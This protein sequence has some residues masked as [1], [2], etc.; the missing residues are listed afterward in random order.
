MQ[1]QACLNIAEAQPNLSKCLYSILL[2]CNH[3]VL[4]TEREPEGQPRR[5]RGDDEASVARS[6]ARG[7][8]GIIT[9]PNIAQRSNFCNL[10]QL[11]QQKNCTLL[12]ELLRGK[13]QRGGGI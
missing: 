6:A 8:I 9:R 10:V 5:A 1:Y 12:H 4:A 7:A 13:S 11:L 2:D 3:E